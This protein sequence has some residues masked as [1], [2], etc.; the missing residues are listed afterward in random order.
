[1]GGYCHLESA[2]TAQDGGGNRHAGCINE[3][4]VG[5]LECGQFEGAA[6]HRFT[7]VDVV[8]S[9]LQD[10]GAALAFA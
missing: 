8:S 9:E 2:S 1:M 4:A 10:S 5:Y 7:A 6:T 3:V